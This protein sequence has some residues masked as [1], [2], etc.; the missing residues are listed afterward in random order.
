MAKTSKI[1]CTNHFKSTD[2]NERKKTYNELW[3][4]LINQKENAKIIQG[5]QLSKNNVYVPLSR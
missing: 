4:N 3:I 2:I 5:L 1:V